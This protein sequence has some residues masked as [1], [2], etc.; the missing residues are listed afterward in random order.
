[1]PRLVVYSVFRSRHSGIVETGGFVITVLV[2]EDSPTT[3][4]FLVHLLSG[5]MIQVIGTASNGAEAVEFVKRTKP[6][7]ITMDIHM[8]GMDGIEATRRIMETVPIPIVIVSANWDPREVEM[9]FRAMEA[10][11]LAL[12][13]RPPGA[14][15]PDHEA[16]VS[17]LVQKVWLMSE[18][19]VVRRWSRDKM[20]PMDQRT[21]PVELRTDTQERIDIV[22]MGASTGGPPV[23][24]TILNNIP[25]DFPAPLLIVQHMA[26]GFLPGMLGWLHETS[27]LQLSIASDGEQTLPGHAYFAPDERQM[28]I[29]TDGRI[30]LTTGER[31]HGARPS[32][33]YLFRSVAQV[34]GK[35]AAG[36]LLTGMGSDG[37]REMKLLKEKG[38]VT[39]AQ[40]KETSAV[41]G[42]PAAA[43]ELDAAVYVLSPE[44]IPDALTG[45]TKKSG[46]GGKQNA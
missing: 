21:K 19:K 15:H 45:M 6:D 5:P 18:V 10:G 3:R 38:A 27:A 41:Y 33:S 4:D 8:P 35:N 23:L 17:E 13:R 28:G 11:A 42:M 39:I 44:Q 43:V 25:G 9:T 31:E 14:G 26:P 2:V 24:Q 32:V 16:A 34:Y 46:T 12:V 20:K 29:R 7:V 22:A 1:L 40:N 37:A 36:I 30:I